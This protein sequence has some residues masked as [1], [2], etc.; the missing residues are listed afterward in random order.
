[1][2]RS[3]R[4]PTLR[5]LVEH[6]R[7]Y[8][9][10]E[11]FETADAFLT[12]REMGYLCRHLRRV[13]PGW[14]LTRVQRQ[15]LVRRLLADQMRPREVADITGLTLGRVYQVRAEDASTEEALSDDDAEGLDIVEL[16]A[17]PASRAPP[18]SSFSGGAGD[19][20]PR[21]KTTAERLLRPRSHLEG[22]GEQS[23][24]TMAVVPRRMLIRPPYRVLSTYFL[25]SRN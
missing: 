24:S 19:C 17:N 4:R 23:G 22:I 7:L 20:L 3:D 21:H 11:V 8:G 18:F 2:S 14:S 16:A 9:A 13:D 15:S 1:M 12:A 5:Q 10:E 6:A 25:L